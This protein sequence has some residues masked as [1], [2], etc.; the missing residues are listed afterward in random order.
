VTEASGPGAG[1]R[2]GRDDLLAALAAR[3]D[4]ALLQG[5]EA[6]LAPDARD[7]AQ[8]LAKLIDPR[9][10]CDVEAVML[11]ATFHL[12]RWR[13]L[14]EGEDAWD[15]EQMRSW[16]TVAGGIDPM[17][18]P[19]P[20]RELVPQR[21][22]AREDVDVAALNAQAAMLTSRFDE[23]GE[24]GLLDHGIVLW[25]RCLGQLHCDQ[26][27]PRATILSNLSGALVTRSETFDSL[28]D[29]DEAVAAAREAVRIS[30][31]GHEL[32][33]TALGHLAAAMKS[34]FE[35]GGDPADLDEAI[36]VGRRAVAD[37]YR[38]HRSRF[39]FLMNLATALRL[40]FEFIGRLSRLDEAVALAREALT[41]ASGEDALVIMANLCGLRR[42]RFEEI[43]EQPDIDQAVDLGRM[44][45]RAT[46]PGHPQL[47]ARL[48]GLSGALQVRAM[49]V[50]RRDDITE[51]VQ[52]ARLAVAAAPGDHPHRGMCESNLATA[53]GT[54]IA[55][56]TLA[57][58]KADAATRT[59]DLDEMIRA[60][61][62]ALRATSAGHPDRAGHLNNLGILLRQRGRPEDLDESVAVARE[63]AA[64]TLPG[65][66]NWC[67][68]MTN[69]GNALE[70]RY[71]RTS[72]AEDL[73]Q[74]FSA[75][76]RAAASPTGASQVRLAA[77]IAWGHRAAAEDDAASAAKGFAVGVSLLP[78]LAWRGLGRGV[79]EE[80][81]ALR[82]GLAGHAAAW[83]I[84]NGS[85][86][87]A[88]EL[89]EQGRSVLWAQQ[90][91]MQTDVDKLAGLDPRLKEELEETRRALDSE[92]R[93]GPGERG[94]PHDPE[95]QAAWHR[96][97]A[98]RWDDLVAQVRRIDGLGNF[99]AAVPFGQ[100]QDGAADGPVVVVNTSSYGCDALVV[101]STGV[102]VIPL[103]ALDYD[104]VTSRARGMLA[105][106]RDDQGRPDDTL[107]GILAWLWET[108]ARPV[109][110]ALGL[111]EPLGPAGE[112][113]A[114]R[115]RLWWCPTGPLALLPLHA[116]GSYEDEGAAVPE[117][118]IASYTS[119]L[120]ALIRARA[121]RTETAP[122]ALLV[123]VPYAPGQDRLPNVPD[124]L[125]R[126][127][128]RLRSATTL[129]GESAT[130][131]AVVAAMP[132]HEWVHLACHGRQDAADPS[133]SSVLLSDGPLSILDI[134]GRLLPSCDL[135]FLSACETFTGTQRLS[136]EAIH[137]A[138][139][140]QVAGYRHV[141][142][143]LW[144]I[145]DNVAP[146]VADR[147]YQ[148]LT[149]GGYPDSSLAAEAIHVAVAELRARIPRHPQVWAPY[150][151]IGP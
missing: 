39:R 70:A 57:G 111:C 66:Q 107:A 22:P 9:Y 15:T 151:H 99:L 14:P 72:Q 45:V 32:N 150:V 54:E 105:A 7:E 119:T 114:R 138:S 108:V 118:V 89:L 117:R 126:V 128:E 58:E 120:G 28:P 134:T 122:S 140:F 115:R 124:E 125:D 116:A 30:P 19:P 63:A 69:L 29:A 52:F 90:L 75:W 18:V 53:L 56:S 142:A 81:L 21:A 133:A 23:T 10:T 3:I 144:S 73:R 35:Q 79:R 61:R 110:D 55:M 84:R 4:A 47:A 106:L 103:P 60:A 113:T 41:G 94:M 62:A 38:G 49:L 51:A 31:H 33:G 141:I 26:R 87:H 92:A 8:R 86:E 5:P 77:A 11:L 132:E 91:H 146:Q 83:A 82:R 104:E 129:D 112:G 127:R 64:G 130:R 46:A 17:L 96:R 97:N 131:D 139:A 44:A 149:R 13:A 147:V 78:I 88:V 1:L 148:T 40:S 109:L 16:L 102:R 123:G 121:S 65:H 76:E 20:F 2:P 68:H 43:G 50:A 36:A 80:N 95:Q 59:R 37:E 101:E 27:A 67:P 98:E 135:A 48:Y 145:R 71:L 143:T 74:A 6:V 25:R 136:D 137:L 34:R 93:R 12:H 42:L 24:A 100:L 85:A